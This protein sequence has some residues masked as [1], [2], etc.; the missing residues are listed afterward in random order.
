MMEMDLDYQMIDNHLDEVTKCK[1][2]CFEYVNFSKLVN[3][4]KSDTTDQRL[5]LVSRNGMIF[6]SPVSEREA[7]HINSYLC[8]EQAFRVYSNIL[9]AHFLQKA[10]E[11][12]QYNHTI[13]T[14][15]VSYIWDNV[16]AYDK[17]FRRHIKRHPT[18]SWTVILQQAWTMILKDRIRNDYQSHKTRSGN[19]G[20]GNKKE[21]CKRFNKEKCTY[22]LSCKIEHQCSVPKCG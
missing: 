1:I 6:L 18:R 9:T 16:Y 17:E 11:L 13:H 19:S 22:R 14:A 10:T 20:A 12:L 4:N 7:F 5:E 15:S 3:H 2:Q 21:I 8:W